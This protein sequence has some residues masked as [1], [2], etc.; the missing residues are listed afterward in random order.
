MLYNGLFHLL[1]LVLEHFEQEFCGEFLCIA[2]SV[3]VA[4]VDELFDFDPTV[5][6]LCLDPSLG[7]LDCLL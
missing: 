1:T 7:T 2:L 6:P 3:N 4:I 5:G